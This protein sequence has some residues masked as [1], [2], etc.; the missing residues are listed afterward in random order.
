LTNNLF[1]YFYF[2]AWFNVWRESTCL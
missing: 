2:S 1:Y